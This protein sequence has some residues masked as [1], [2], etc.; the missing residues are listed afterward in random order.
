MTVDIT[1]LNDLVWVDPI[2]T[3]LETDIARRIPWREEEPLHPRLHDR[4]ARCA[5]R[6]VVIYS[7]RTISGVK[8]KRVFDVSRYTGLEGSG[9][10]RRRDC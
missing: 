4:V 9:C 5:S 2:H 1:N 10:S 3:H 6:V 8:A 7:C